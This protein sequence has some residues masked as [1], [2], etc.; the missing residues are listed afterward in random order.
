MARVSELAAMVAPL[1]AM[2]SVLYALRMVGLAS[3]SLEEWW[4]ALA[5]R[6][7]ESAGPTFIK[8]CQWAATRNDVFPAAMTRRFAKLH[9]SVAPHD[10]R[11]TS[12]ALDVA[13]GEGW[14]ER[15][16]LGV[17][18][19]GSGCIAQVYRGKATD[20]SGETR[21]VAVKV[22]HPN[23]RKVVEIDMSLLRWVGE[24]IEALLPSLR[25]L[26]VVETLSNF[27]FLMERQLDLRIEAYNL[28]RLAALFKNDDT[29]CIPQPVW[30]CGAANTSQEV[31][32]ATTDK[33]TV[34]AAKRETRWSSRDVLVEEY[35]EGRPITSFVGAESAS[36]LAKRGAMALLRMVLQHNFVHGD[37]HPGNLLVDSSHRIVLLDAGIC[38]ELPQRAHDNMV[39]MLRAMLEARGHDAA[40][41]MLASDAADRTRRERDAQ[42][43]TNF[44]QGIAAMVD[45]ARNQ[46]F[47]ES[48]AEYYGDICNLAIQNR[49]ALDAS[50]VS[51]ALAVKIVE[52]LVMDLHPNFPILELALPMF[53]KAQFENASKDRLS[54]LSENS[55]RILS[56]YDDDDLSMSPDSDA[57]EFAF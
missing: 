14:R 22:V 43:E 19:L 35:V 55:L 23:V 44:V 16:D 56:C 21:D 2:A 33:V 15:L 24:A 17:E 6:M 37:L 10:L 41:L 8:L 38:I 13:F 31:G 30:L 1:A 40:R 47:F 53:L 9:D 18:V 46:A 32:D 39:A 11:H 34:V 54:R 28:E 48:I 25:Y 50:F 26:G 27:E 49:V 42:N 3:P 29:V 51:I 36:L 12:Q 7:V 45:R 20:A 52:G 4:W 57:F 5:L